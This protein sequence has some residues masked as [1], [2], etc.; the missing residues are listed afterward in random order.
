MLGVGAATLLV[1]L[2]DCAQPGREGVNVTLNPCQILMDC[3]DG[4]GGSWVNTPA[5]EGGPLWV[6]YLPWLCILW[7]TWF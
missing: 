3:V 7:P 4:R 5:L 6:N 2:E 1:L